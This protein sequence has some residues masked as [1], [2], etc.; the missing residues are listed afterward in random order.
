M[1]RAK[2]GHSHLKPTLAL[3]KETL[4][5][6]ERK[7]KRKKKRRGSHQPFDSLLL[8]LFGILCSTLMFSFGETFIA[9]PF[10]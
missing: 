4:K 10:R 1:E 9:V 5:R 6:G 8:P 7:G 2:R 3:Q